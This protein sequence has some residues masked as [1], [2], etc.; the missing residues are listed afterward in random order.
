MSG[1]QMPW[2]SFSW[3]E[4]DFATGIDSATGQ[5]V[6]SSALSV[7]PRRFGSAPVSALLNHRLLKVKSGGELIVAGG[8]SGSGD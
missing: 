8:I 4:G 2:F 7:L 5:S 1:A 6:A 3:C